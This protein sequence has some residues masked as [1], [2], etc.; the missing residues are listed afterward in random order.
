MP[1]YSFVEVCLGIAKAGLGRGPEAEGHFRR[2]LVLDPSD[3]QSYRFFARWLAENGRAPQAAALLE[4]AMKKGAADVESRLL[5]LQ[6]YLALGADEER[7]AL[8]AES[9]E[10]APHHPE[11]RR[12]RREGPP[13]P[14]PAA[15]PA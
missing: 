4:A 14:R 9:L 5:L 1:R 3:P 12:W 8:L 15:P 11:L 7:E 13:R 10:I 2:A 6:L